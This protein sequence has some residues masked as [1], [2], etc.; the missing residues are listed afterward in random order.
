MSNFKLY[1]N[2]VRNIN[3]EGMMDNIKNI[4][5]T[6]KEKVVEIYKDLDTADSK[7]LENFKEAFKAASDY[8]WKPDEKFNQVLELVLVRMNTAAGSPMKTLYSI[9]DKNLNNQ[10]KRIAN[11]IYT[12]FFRNVVN[13][14]V[15]SFPY[16]PSHHG[17][18]IKNTD[19][20]KNAAY[21]VKAIPEYWKKQKQAEQKG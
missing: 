18:L 10:Q 16:P 14:P 11:S 9:T 1:L 5:N 20:A 4:T 13:E 12:A 8:N 19:L 15:D 3:E 2:K 21:L 7:T 6:V 17:H